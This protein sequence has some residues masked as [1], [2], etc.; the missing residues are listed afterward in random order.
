M[1]CNVNWV[2]LR[3]LWGRSEVPMRYVWGP[4]CLWGMSEFTMRYVWGLRC[5]WGMSEVTMRYV[6]G[7]YEVCLRFL[8]GTK[9]PR[10][11]HLW[12]C[13]MCEAAYPQNICVMSIYGLWVCM[14]CVCGYMSSVAHTQS[15]TS[16]HTHTYTHTHLNLISRLRRLS[17][18]RA[19]GTAIQLYYDTH[20]ET[21]T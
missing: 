6:W 17:V 10:H 11:N 15:H 20:V 16:T 5:L 8:W 1:R 14:G 21:H 2:C 12:G 18:V 7:P 13:S 9:S 3:S 19:T 4:R